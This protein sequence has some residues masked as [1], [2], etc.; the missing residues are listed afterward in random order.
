DDG[1]TGGDTMTG[2]TGGDTMTGGTGGDTMTGGTGGD[3]MTGGG[4]TLTGGVKQFGQD[5]IYDFNADED[6]IQIAGFGYGNAEELFSSVTKTGTTLSGSYYTTL[7]I[8][9]EFQLTIFSSSSLSVKNFTVGLGSLPSSFGGS[10]LQEL[11][12]VVGISSG[13]K[14]KIDNRLS[15]A[16]FKVKSKS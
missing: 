2:G 10:S 12:K 16:G 6:V 11:T 8:S 14:V 4:D 9:Q 5:V 15:S 13:L 1:G 3:T 7:A